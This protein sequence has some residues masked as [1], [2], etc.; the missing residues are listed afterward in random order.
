MKQ[1]GSEVHLAVGKVACDREGR[2]RKGVASVMLA[3]RINS[4]DQVR[5]VIQPNHG[6]FTIPSDH[7]TLMIRVGPGT[8]AAPFVAF[9]RERDQ[10]SAA[11]PGGWFLR[12][13]HE[14][15]DFLYR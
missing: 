5:V 2:E 14:S 13:Q 6:G 4:G 8:G 11:G 12:D 10:V 1:V 3:D 7:E 15:T 9:R